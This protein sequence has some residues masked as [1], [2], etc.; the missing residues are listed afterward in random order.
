M[1]RRTGYPQLCGGMNDAT[2]GSMSRFYLS[3]QVS[4]PAAYFT[5]LIQTKLLR[6]RESYI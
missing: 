3:L 1:E 5:I 2:E 4:V 6:S